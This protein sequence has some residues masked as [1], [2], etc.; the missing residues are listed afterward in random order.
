MKKITLVSYP[1]TTDFDNIDTINHIKYL[2]APPFSILVVTS[3]LRRLGITVT[4]FNTDNE[5]RRHLNSGK[6]AKAF[7][8]DFAER[9]SRNVDSIVGFSSICNSYYITLAIAKELKTK[10]PD[11][12]VLL[13]GPH[14]T[15]TA[16]KTMELCPYVDFILAGEVEDSLESFSKYYDSA[17]NM[18]P[19]LY[20][21]DSL[22]KI[23]YN[24]LGQPPD[25]KDMPLPA[26]DLCEEYTVDSFMVE[27]GRG[28]PFHCRYCS[29]SQFFR[30][31]YRLRS[32]D[33]IID[34]AAVL[35]KK[36]GFSRIALL[37]DNLFHAR[38]KLLAF[39][40]KWKNDPRSK[41][42]T[43]NCS[44]RADSISPEIAEELS[45]S[46]CE[47]VFIG[48]ETGSQ[49]MQQI[50]QKRLKVDKVRQVI[51]SLHKNGVRTTVAFM[52]GFPEEQQKEMKITLDL[53]CEML[54]RKL[55]SP[56]IDMLSP[57]NG[58]QYYEEYKDTLYYD[59]LTSA[60]AHQG[61]MLSNVSVYYDD[62]VRAAPE[63]FAA[64]YALPLKYLER[65]FVFECT[66]FLR[67]A[68]YN[69][70]WLL[71]MAVH[72]IGDLYSVIELFLG[73]KKETASARQGIRYYSSY[74]F[75]EDFL[76]F[77]AALP[78]QQVF[79]QKYIDHYRSM[80]DAYSITEEQFESLKGMAYE[81]SHIDS[82]LLTLD[83][84]LVV[85]CLTRL[86]RYSFKEIV[87]AFDNRR[88]VDAIQPKKSAI[89]L[90]TQDER[91]VIEQVPELILCIVTV[92]QDGEIIAKALE[93]LTEKHADLL[94]ARVT[95]VRQGFLFAIQNLVDT[96]YL[97]PDYETLK[98]PAMSAV[99]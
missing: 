29:T 76:S 70:R 58:S 13:G 86:S 71:V 15:A 91:I 9:V 42:L 18:V 38:S 40:R 22:D 99:G 37:H 4:L 75:L 8:A 98:K 35:N 14:A 68:A 48:V 6:E 60:M 5:Y 54:C 1:T 27:A 72:A 41:H 28:C 21:R 52:I 26:Y 30:R 96:G 89:I 90:R 81:K 69:L 25:L 93:K 56:Q 7:C 88:P 95:N 20:W 79:K 47:S 12:H 51:D 46:G 23:H 61:D 65:E 80:L 66:C 59:E 11:I 62:M 57:V 31:N 94:P 49:R 50:I 64:H 36:F 77:A 73:H 43:W 87:D 45:N 92:F 44:I 67:Y 17:P 63:L 34:E 97:R 2:K 55:S 24:N 10:R 19:G 3:L 53:Y 74:D 83:D 84:R 32:F 39:C 33:A 82:L 85:T 16:E 78:Q